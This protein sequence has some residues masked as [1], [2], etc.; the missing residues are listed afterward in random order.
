MPTPRIIGLTGLAGAG[1]DT[2]RE[3]LEQDHDFLGIAFAT[4]IRSMLTKL[5]DLAGADPAYIYDRELKETAIPEIGASYRQLAQTLGTEWGRSISP[6]LWTRIAAA[7][8]AKDHNRSQR[9][10]ISDVRFANEAAW[11]REQGGEIWR[12][13]RP[14]ATAVRDHASEHHAHTIRADRVIDNG[15]TFEQ[16]WCRV[17]EL[18][19]GHDTQRRAA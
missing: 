7:Q 4:P 11:V 14:D 3:I 13:V 9:Y 2:V 18:A 10:V 8:I 19:S 5:I 15:G 1:K 6:D 17:S 12:I 16:L